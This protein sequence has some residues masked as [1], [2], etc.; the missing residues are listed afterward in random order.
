MK[1]LT[2]VLAFTLPFFTLS[3]KDEGREVEYLHAVSLQ[4]APNA[5]NV[6]KARWIVIELDRPVRYSSMEEIGIRYLNDSDSI[7]IRQ[8][9]SPKG[10]RYST[11]RQCPRS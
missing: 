3:C 6:D 2:N 5:A 10:D 1:T 8:I 9:T 4:P 7:H 11:R